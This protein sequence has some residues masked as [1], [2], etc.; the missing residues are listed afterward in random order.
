MDCETLEGITLSAFQGL[1]VTM[2]FKT[3]IMSR[4]SR[5][6]PCAQKVGAVNTLKIQEKEIVGYNT[7]YQAIHTVLMNQTGHHVV[8]LGTGGA[9]R[10]TYMAA[11]D[12]NKDVVMVS[13]QPKPG[14]LNWFEA[15]QQIQ[16]AHIVVNATPLGM[17]HFPEMPQDMI[18]TQGLYVEWV[19]HPL[20]TPALQLCQN[21][22][23]KTIDGLTL[24]LLQAQHAFHIWT[25]VMPDIQDVRKVLI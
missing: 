3:E 11:Q 15:K 22:D 7:D 4:V 1:N 23:L 10:A 25:G 9:A 21:R 8:V 24:L 12:L 19:Y 17:S 2:P 13:R 20:I 14:M 6:M 18:P 5:V 16:K